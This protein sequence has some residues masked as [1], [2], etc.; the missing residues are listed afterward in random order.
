MNKKARSILRNLSYTV[1]ANFATLAISILLNLFVPKFLGVTEYSY[2]QLYVFYSSY[3]GFLHFGWIDGIYL[4][5]GGE[6]YDELDKKTLGSQF[7]YLVI[8]EIIIS[9]IVIFCTFHLVVRKHQSL[10]LILTA[11]ESVV[12]IAKTY[13]LY[14]FQST[15]RIK[16]Y[17]QL[18]RNDRYMYLLFVGIY[19]IIGGRDFYWLIIM[20]ILSK[21]FMTLWGMIRIKDMVTKKCLPLKNMYL[22][23]LDN[24]SIGSKLMISNVASMLILGTIRFFVQQRWSIETFG[25]LSF[26]LSISNMA[27]TFINAIGIVMF[28]LLRRTNRDKLPKL[29][30]TLRNIFV[31][32]TYGLLLFYIPAKLIL[33]FWLPAYQDSLVYMGI[34]FP[35]VVYEGRMS[36]LIN[37]YLKSLREEKKI[38]FVNVVTL[39]I[40]IIFSLI[41]VFVFGNLTF[42]VI[43]IIFCLAFRCNLAELLLCRAINVKLGYQIILETGLTVSFVLCNLIFNNPQISLVLYGICF[44]SYLLIIRRPVIVSSLDLLNMIK[45]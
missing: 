26:I 8:L 43:L 36:L 39:L 21:V 33:E 41:T 20:D 11:V 40:S 14:I 31:P 2:W 25:K 23:I 16:E 44:V 4:K 42:S 37:T 24:I 10:I 18:S 17:A 13:I 45:K 15:N 1:T 30:L 19:L 28:P 12:I 35:I 5:I 38:L 29:F 9:S 34:L 7:W 3:V 27:L 22:E 6:E 32:L